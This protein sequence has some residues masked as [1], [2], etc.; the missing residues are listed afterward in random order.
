VINLARRSRMRL[1]SAPFVMAVAVASLLLL[2]PSAGAQSTY[3]L[4]VSTSPDR[5]N[6]LSLHGYVASE[7]IYVFT[8]TTSAGVNQVRFY[9]DN[10]QMT[11]TP[12]RIEAGAPH[13]L[14]GTNTNGTSKPLSTSTLSNGPHT[15]TAAID[16]SAGGTQVVSATFTVNNI[17][18]LRVSSASNRSNSQQL[19]GATVSKN[20]YVFS[21][22]STGVSEV[23]FF[24]DDPTMAAAPR[25]V[26]RGAP[27]DLQG[28]N[29]DGTAKP[30]NTKTLGNGTHTVTAAMT[31]TGGG[32]EVVTS[33]FTV[34][35]RTECLLD[36]S[37][38]RVDVPYELTFNE[39]RGRLLEKDGT[40]TGFT[41]IDTPDTGTGYKPEL[42]DVDTVGGHLEITTTAGIAHASENS[43]DNAVGAGFQAPNQ[44]SRI[45]TTIENPP[46]GSGN[47]EQAGLY[48]GNDQD[49]YVKLIVMSS[50]EGNRLQSALE[51]KGVRVSATTTA[52]L[53][54]TNS[55]VT[56]ALVANPFDRTVKPSYRI[57]GGASKA[58]GSYTA[59]GEFFSFDAAGID[60]NI[61]T[62]SFAGILA[63][64][65]QGPAPVVYRF[66]DF[67]ITKDSGDTAPPVVSDI[68]FDDAA[69]FS[70]S[71]P[72]SMAFGPDGRLYVSELFG[73]IHALTL[74]ADRQLVADQVI[75]TLGSRL[76]LGLTVDPAST[77][78][79]VVLWAS[80]SSPSLDAGVPNSGMVTRLSG[81]GFAT[82]QDV[83]TGLPRAI[84][85]HGTNSIHFGPDGKLYIAQG[86]NTGAGAPN[87]ANTEF[88]TMQEQP[89][90]AAMLVADVKA[91]GFDGSCNN[92]S[93]IFGPPP[94]D[95]VTYA[96]G[97]RNAYDF[98]WHTNGSLYAPDNGL[99]VAGTFPPSPSP[100]CF[101]FGN[102]APWTQG[103]HNPGEQADY[104]QRVEPGRYY[105]H[106]NPHRQECVFAD[107]RYQNVGPLA[108]Y[109]APFFKLGDHRSAD[110]TIEYLS[111]RFCG[112]L[113]GDILIANF[114]VGDNLTRV[115]LANDGLSVVSSNSLVGGFNDPLSLT[116]DAAGNIYVGEFGPGRVRVLKPID[117]G[118]W[119]TESPAPA[120]VLDA[121]GTSLNGK[122]YVVAGKTAS[123][124][125]STVNVYDAAARTWSTAAPLPGPAVENPAVVAHNGKLYAFG[126]S[127]APFAGAVAN[128][129]V[130][131]PGTNVW[132][133]LPPMATA[134]AGAAAQ[135]LGGKIYVVGGMAGNG[136]SLPT[137]EVF[138]L[139][140]GTWSAGPSMAVRRDNPGAAALNGKLY[141][142]GGRTRN[143]DASV[144]NDTLSSAEML[145]PAE[146]AWVARAQMPTGR[147]TMVVGTLNGKAQVVGGEVSPGGGAFASNEEYDPATDTWR[148]L[149]SMPTA[150]HGAVGGVIN[151]RFH[152]VGGGP[153]SGLTFTNAHEIFAF[154]Q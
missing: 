82:R 30:F 140:A 89:L 107:G 94:C 27:F 8:N 92:T 48:F 148:R 10:P 53:D 78:S 126:G 150:R 23:K 130:Y 43:Q 32:S 1:F 137:V 19:E 54:L 143:A 93:D 47:F 9:L 102:T 77:P 84:A 22:P 5:S 113:Q 110:G 154:Q 13:D 33:S 152:V 128:A 124:H 75:T 125:R 139:A 57:N 29:A 133:A 76:T 14:Q 121:G 31:K 87:N 71:N 153:T 144:V 44:V 61:G 83:I 68:T 134:R 62:R 100:P 67:S 7:N 41:Y 58:L 119:S 25:F 108:N 65:R 101:G 105:G 56:F 131:D 123:G 95:V 138:D 151:G 129:S 109:S 52:P 149:R 26:E 135:V 55:S 28:T 86:G 69:R 50:P 97:L 118:C 145:D 15:V 3:Q 4:Q 142:F 18:D 39:D 16:L 37:L 46:A 103:G 112:D 104:L 17:F 132:T 127:T 64:H 81:P 45:Q 40:G 99:G 98:V 117:L 70:V 114:S 146:G 115:Q 36:C 74:N 60:P 66:N 79:N 122:L 85:N 2:L 20:M 120:E 42:L 12:Y 111:N 34:D 88:G 24:V 96:T 51:V 106:P 72:T 59:P 91:A 11:G 38:I 21:T 141:V 73:R 6:P 90:S 80:H 35:N 116:Q 49:N 136:A 63:T 147:R